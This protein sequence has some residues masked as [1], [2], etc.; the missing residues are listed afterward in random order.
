MHQKKRK[1]F[2]QLKSF[3][4]DFTTESPDLKPERIS[5]YIIIPLP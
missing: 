4:T 1:I 5:D 3:F 2:L